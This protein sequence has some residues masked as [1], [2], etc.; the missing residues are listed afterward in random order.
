MRRVNLKKI[1]RLRKQKKLTQL[2]MAQ[3]LGYESDV[4]YHYLETGRCKIKAEQLDVIASE[5]GV[6]TDDLYEDETTDTVVGS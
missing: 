6:S 5:F 2:Y 1:R 3:K 4:G